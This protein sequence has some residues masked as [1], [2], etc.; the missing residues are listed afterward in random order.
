MFHFSNLFWLLLKYYRN[1]LDFE[2][3]CSFQFWLNRLGK[4]Y[5][6]F[7]SRTIFCRHFLRQDKD[8]KLILKLNR[9]WS[10]NLGLTYRFFQLLTFRLFILFALFFLRVSRNLVVDSCLNRRR[11]N[12]RWQRVLLLR[13]V[14]FTSNFSDRFFLLL[15]NPRTLQA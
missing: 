2:F 5:S 10:L 12:K 13:N 4:N 1:R 9:L 7:L 6:R 8:R 14:P 11:R 3:F 15:L